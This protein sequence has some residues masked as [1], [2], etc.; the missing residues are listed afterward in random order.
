MQIAQLANCRVNH[1][2]CGTEQAVLTLNAVI[3]MFAWA[4]EETTQFAS[5]LI[6]T[7]SYYRDVT[8][9]T[10]RARGE[11]TGPRLVHRVA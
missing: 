2:G 9:N 8:R 7:G 5:A 3:A 1:V 11:A 4:A 6:A 10:R